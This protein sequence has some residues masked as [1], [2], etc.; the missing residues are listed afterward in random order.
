M[1][2][3]EAC[4]FCNQLFLNPN[5]FGSIAGY[6]GMVRLSHQYTRTYESIRDNAELGCLMCAK[7]WA[8]FRLETSL[9]DGFN[10]GLDKGHEHE[11]VFTMNFCRYVIDQLCIS[12]TAAADLAGDEN[13][14]TLEL[15]AYPGSCPSNCRL[16]YR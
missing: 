14:L 9:W 10:L 2:T 4:S 6:K 13:W 7:L 8:W 1:A 16:S 15:F 5:L 11:V 12:L 3:H